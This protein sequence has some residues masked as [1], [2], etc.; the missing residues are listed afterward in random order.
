[1]GPHASIAAPAQIEQ[2]STS[3]LLTVP[4]TIRVPSVSVSALTI[5]PL[6]GSF[7]YGTAE[8]IATTIALQAKALSYSIATEP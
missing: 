6:S 3:V 2:T 1:M 5:H 7:R 8:A 4:S